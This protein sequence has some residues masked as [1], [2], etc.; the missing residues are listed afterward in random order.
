MKHAQKM[1]EKTQADKQDTLVAYYT[2]SKKQ[3]K[4]TIVEFDAKV[5]R[6]HVCKMLNV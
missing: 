6:L 2:E 3:V 5:S 1:I 4:K